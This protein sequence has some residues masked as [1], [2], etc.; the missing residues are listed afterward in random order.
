LL[1][2]SVVEV[3]AIPH[4]IMFT[5]NLGVWNALSLTDTLKKRT[6][7]IGEVR[8]L[9]IRQVVFLCVPYWSF[10]VAGNKS[11]GNNICILRGKPTGKLD[12]C[13]FYFIEE[14]DDVPV[15]ATA[16]VVARRSLNRC[17]GY[18][19]QTV[20][21]YAVDEF[22]NHFR[23]KR[24]TFKILVRQVLGTG[25]LPNGNVFARKVIARKQVSIFLWCITNQETT[26]LVA[27]RFDVTFSSV[28]RVVRRVTDSVLAM[29]N[30]YI[31]WPNGRNFS[32]T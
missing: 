2:S 16:A 13:L 23:M 3:I 9:C 14:D 6:S 12:T 5:I 8:G 32:F 26:R 1:I 10:R 28:S 29:R 27:D 22:Q 17:Q 11:T 15:V 21:F 18:F 7:L 24:A 30:Q 31:K 19:E 20:P 4:T 25:V